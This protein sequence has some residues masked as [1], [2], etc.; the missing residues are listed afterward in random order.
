VI[1]DRD[2]IL[3]QN[4][5]DN[6]EE[7]ALDYEEIEMDID[8][9][10]TRQDLKSERNKFNDRSSEFNKWKKFDEIAKASLLEN[11]LDNDMLSELDEMMEL[12]DLAMDRDEAEKWANY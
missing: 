2:N 5:V 6:W 12:D 11:L 8:D 9:K 10:S 4:N 1:I 7:S 3:G